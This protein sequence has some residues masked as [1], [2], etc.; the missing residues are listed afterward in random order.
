MAVKK[1]EPYSPT[2]ERMAN[3]LARNYVTIKPCAKCGAPHIVIYCC[4]HCGTSDPDSA[5]G[6]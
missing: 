3:S 5:E 2:Y 1:I 4:G 6:E